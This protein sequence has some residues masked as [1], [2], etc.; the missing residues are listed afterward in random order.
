M[1]QH[2]SVPLD[3]MDGV[4][5]ASLKYHLSIIAED[6][7]HLQNLLSQT[8][9]DREIAACGETLTQVLRNQVSL[10]EALS[11]YGG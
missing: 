3:L 8:T 10:N 1:K 4:V 5:I 7:E 11:Y 6:I 2:V 9:D